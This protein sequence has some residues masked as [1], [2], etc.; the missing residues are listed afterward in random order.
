MD[1]VPETWV[2]YNELEKESDSHNLITVMYFALT[3]LSTVGYGDYYPIH[4]LEQVKA[5]I[6]MLM[7]VAVFSWVRDE[8]MGFVDDQEIEYFER[9]FGQ[10]IKGL[11]RFPGMIPQTV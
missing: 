2:H 10:W 7:G 8:I 3:M 9:S 4:P 5:I 1:E 6:I 11:E